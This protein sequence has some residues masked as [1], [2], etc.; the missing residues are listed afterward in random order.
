MIYSLD[1][2]DGGELEPIRGLELYALRNSGALWF[3]KV[4]YKV[5]RVDTLLPGLDSIWGPR[6]ELGYYPEGVRREPL[7]MQAKP[8]SSCLMVYCAVDDITR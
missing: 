5:G 3:A 7:S 2:D 4:Q 8:C 1:E 6:A